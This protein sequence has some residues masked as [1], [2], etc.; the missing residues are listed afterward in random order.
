M[1]SMNLHYSQR[2]KLESF[3]PCHSEIIW[4]QKLS[5]LNKDVLKRS[6]ECTP[7]CVTEQQDI[8]ENGMEK[9]S[10]IYCS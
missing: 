5:K 9:S 10:I 7:L 4:M 8:L 2:M 3:L 1:T 6:T